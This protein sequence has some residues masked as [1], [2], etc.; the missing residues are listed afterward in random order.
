MG[1]TKNN[2][3]AK[4]VPLVGELLSQV[5]MDFAK[6]AKALS[7]HLKKSVSEI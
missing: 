2:Q 5:H 1:E 3:R 7:D 4:V 6:I